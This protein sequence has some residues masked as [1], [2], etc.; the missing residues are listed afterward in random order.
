MSGT[1]SGSGPEHPLT[2]E[3][4]DGEPRRQT[5]S[6]ALVQRKYNSTGTAF[7]TVECREC[8]TVLNSGHHYLQDGKVH[9]ERLAAEHNKKH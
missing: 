8:F 3:T 7:F 1:L 4:V 6:A 2:V 9:A 5:M